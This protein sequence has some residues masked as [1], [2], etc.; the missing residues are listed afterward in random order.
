MLQ[1]QADRAQSDR[2]QWK[3]IICKLYTSHTGCSKGKHCNY[4]HGERDLQQ[5]K[6]QTCM[7]HL[8]G[9]CTFGSD[10][11]DA[12]SDSELRRQCK[13]HFGY[14]NGCDKGKMCPFSH[15]KGSTGSSTG[16]AP[17]DR[18][19]SGDGPGQQDVPASSKDDSEESGWELAGRRPKRTTDED[20]GP[21]LFTPHHRFPLPSSPFLLSKYSW[22]CVSYR[23]GRTIRDPISVFDCRQANRDCIRRLPQGNAVGVLCA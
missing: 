11:R 19:G 23:T 21:Y 5:F 2:A 15:E 16:T 4:A 17:T 7:Y 6:T 20:A 14:K 1:L 18:K 3:K 8:E 13:F 9:R 12:H 22:A 10:C